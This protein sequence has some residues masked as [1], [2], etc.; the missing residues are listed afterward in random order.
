M[1]SFYVYILKCSDGSY[2]VGHTE[3]LDNRMNQYYKVGT[4]SGYVATRLPVELV[5]SEAMETRYDALVA[6]RQIKKW[7]RKKKEALIVGGWEALQGFSRK[8]RK[9]H[10][11]K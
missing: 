7:S 6:E 4:C 2:Y 11:E 8:N 5:W 9:A 1:L 3:D 10:N